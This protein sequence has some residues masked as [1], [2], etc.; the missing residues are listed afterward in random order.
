MSMPSGPHDRTDTGFIAGAAGAAAIVLGGLVLLGWTFDVAMLRSIIPGRTAMNPGGTALAFLLS[1]VSLLAQ[2]RE[3]MTPPRRALGSACAAAVLVIGL[4]RLAGYLVGWDGGPDRWLFREGLQ[5]EA[6]SLGQINR[7][8]PNTAAAFV[9]VAVALALLEVETRRGIRPA[10]FLALG[11]GLIALLALI[12]Y[13]Y[14]AVLLIGVRWFIPMALNTAIGFAILSAGILFARPAWGLMAVVTSRGAGGAMAQRLLPAVVLV[15]AAV[16][17]MVWRAQQGGLVS[18]VMG[19]SLFVVANIVIFTALVWWNAAL[20]ER[21]DGGRRRA[22]RRLGIQYTA[23]RVLAES[24]RLDDAVPKIL[25]AICESLGWEVGVVWR[26]DPQSGVLRSGDVWHVPASRSDRADEFAALCRGTTFAPG[27]GLPGRVWASGQPAWIP[28]VVSDSNFPR[29]TAAARAGLHGAFGF[30]IV[31][32]SDILGVIEAFSGEIQQPDG[33]LLR[34]LAAIGSQIGQFM[35]RKAAEEAL[36]QGEERLRSLVEA[37][38]AIVWSTPASGEFE[39]EQPGWSAFTG[40]TFDQLRGWGWLDAVHPDDRPTTARVW[41]A[42]VAARSLYQ[43]EHRLR[44]HDGEYRQMLVRAVPILAKGGGIR[45]WVGVHTDIDAERKGEAAMRE[46]KEAAEAATRTKSEF[47]ANMSHEIRTPLNGIIGM[48]GLALD[49]E[50]TPE[51]REYLGMVK[52]SADHLLTV[53]NDI[54][55][56]SKIEAGKLDLECVDF[57]PRDT[58]DDTVAALAMRAHKK[59]LELAEHIASAVPDAL[60]GDP[61]RLRQIVVN[62]IGNAI[63]FTERGEVVLRVEVRS[64]TQERVWLHFTVCDTGIGIAPEQQRKLFKAFSQADTSTTRKYGGTGLGLAISARLVQM[65]GGEIWLES[66]IGRGSTFHFTIPFDVARGPVARPVF[67]KPTQVHGLSVLVVD[68]NAT[69]RRILQDMLTDWGMRPTVAEG[70]EEALAAL[71][72]AR[73]AGEP[74]GLVL[75][76]AM[77]PGM[78]GFALAER[79][80]K[81][82]RSAAPTLMMLSSTN[83]GEDAARCRELGVS[84]CLTKPVKQSTLLDAIMTALGPSASALERHEPAEPLPADGGAR[85]ALLLLLAEDNVV[86]QRLAVSLLEKRGHHVVVVGNG[87][88]ALLALD[89]QPFDAVLLDVQMPEMDGFEATAAIRAREARTGDH[90][91][92][93]AM[94]AHALKGDRERCLAAGMDAYVTKPLRPLELYQV[95][96]GR[97]PDA[98]DAPLGVAPPGAL[99][100]AVALERVD[101]DLEL[102]KELAGLFLDE[103][104]RRMAEIRAAISQ[105]NVLKLQQE[106]HTLKGSVGNFGAQE[107]FEAARRLETVGRGQDW[108]GVEEAWAALEQAIG[109][110][111]PALAGIGQA[112]AS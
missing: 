89:E 74:F 11:V 95:V 8:A 58:L 77:M 94:T 72:E 22:E 111:E 78:D 43:V 16:G 18:E 35:K 80:G 102:L 93:V 15:P 48:T 81:D 97:T 20:L 100:L 66:E 83:R 27:V 14:R 112:G 98:S 38:V 34:M 110:L 25:E 106:A 13:A 47:L 9:L 60:A 64:R 36:R 24:P 51:Q 26:V 41:S 61:H 85:R 57:D 105:R 68:D 1:G 10:Q 3:G 70:G 104:P 101:G 71:E 32:G 39:S 17:W 76:D 50:L 67:G 96:E 109:R 62:L 49:T 54:L 108:T 56:F 46:A 90:T 21:M 33:D 107:T 79:I 87:R 19:L 86:N 53:I 23:S 12:G 84:A 5:R 91:W 4:A 31:V 30:P 69:N 42:A 82:A 29:A 52:V 75:L 92:I 99:D 103:C 45:E 37:T 40:Q 55:D 44:R 59:G 88:E 65:M 2:A 6:V 63:K 7:M 28:D 73:A